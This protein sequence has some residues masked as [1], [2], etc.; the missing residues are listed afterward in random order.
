MFSTLNVNFALKFA[1]EECRSKTV[2]FSLPVEAFP[3]SGA[4]NVIRLP[5]VLVRVLTTKKNCFRTTLFRGAS[6]LRHLR[7]FVSRATHFSVAPPFASKGRSGHGPRAS[8]YFDASCNTNAN[9]SKDF[10]SRLSRVRVSGR[11]LPN[12]SATCAVTW[13]RHGRIQFAVQSWSTEFCYTHNER[14]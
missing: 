9:T 13:F 1:Q 2:F 10:T 12:Q 6:Q 5:L 14:G 7:R 11:S 3:A 4:R 8:A